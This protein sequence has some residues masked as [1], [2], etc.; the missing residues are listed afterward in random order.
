[1]RIKAKR[2]QAETD[3]VQALEACGIVV[4]RVS[5]TGVG[6]LLLYSE[7]ARLFWR[8]RQHVYLP[9]EVKGPKRSLTPAQVVTR[10]K[11]PF[12]VVTTVDEALALV[13]VF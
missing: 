4:I 5:S 11:M 9:A 10:A 1:M 12:P 2:D 3:I 6:D 8:G 13:E 7:S